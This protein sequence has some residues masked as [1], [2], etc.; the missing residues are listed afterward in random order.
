MI[1]FEIVEKSDMV[2]AQIDLFWLCTFTFLYTSLHGNHI[3]I[4]FGL[5]KAETSLHLSIWGKN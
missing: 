3:S 4:G 2:G 5:W 1:R